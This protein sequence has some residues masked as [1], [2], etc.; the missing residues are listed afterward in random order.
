MQWQMEK[1]VLTQAKHDLEEKYESIS[2]KYN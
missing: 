2:Q 1:D